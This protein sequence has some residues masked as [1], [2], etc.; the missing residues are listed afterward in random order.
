MILDVESKSIAFLILIFS[1][2]L[3]SFILKVYLVK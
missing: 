2:W 1:I 3:H